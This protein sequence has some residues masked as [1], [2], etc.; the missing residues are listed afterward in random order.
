MSVEFQVLVSRSAG[1][2]KSV[3]QVS[4]VCFGSS[5]SLSLFFFFF[6]LTRKL[7]HRLSE[8][9]GYIEAVQFS[10]IYLGQS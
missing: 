9:I 7:T 8:L 6:K 5:F 3:T 1:R 2:T 4:S 10:H